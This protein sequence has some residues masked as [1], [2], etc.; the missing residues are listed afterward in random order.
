MARAARAARAAHAELNT[1]SIDQCHL[2]ADWARMA[3]L[4]S[5]FETWG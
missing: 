1:S 3:I 2:V 4:K 5:V